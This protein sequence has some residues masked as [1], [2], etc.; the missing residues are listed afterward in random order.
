MAGHE[1]LRDVLSSEFWGKKAG[2][3]GISGSARN[4]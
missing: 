2:K 4:G 1:N 3:R